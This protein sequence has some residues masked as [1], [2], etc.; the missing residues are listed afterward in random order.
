MSERVIPLHGERVL[1]YE[2]EGAAV[3]VMDVIGRTWESE[4]TTVAIPAGRL[5]TGFFR[6]HTGIAGEFLQKFVNY[7]LRLVVVGDIDDHL[8]RSEALRA[9]VRESNRGDQLWF[10]PDLDALA[11]RLAG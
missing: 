7:R 1:L 3:D 10:V 8:E 4:A 5:E 2:P 11:A 6:L 9:W